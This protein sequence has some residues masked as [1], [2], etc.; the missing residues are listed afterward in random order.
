MAQSVGFA[1]THGE[2]HAVQT[3]E[4]AT[5]RCPKIGIVENF[6]APLLFRPTHDQNIDHES[7]ADANSTLVSE[8]D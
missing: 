3:V 6:Q 1:R 4:S 5:K 2:I 8:L 7:F